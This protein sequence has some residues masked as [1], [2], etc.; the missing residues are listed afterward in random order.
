MC[1]RVHDSLALTCVVALFRMSGIPSPGSMLQKLKLMF[2]L[3]LIAIQR[4]L[5][6]L[7]QQ[8]QQAAAEGEGGAAATTGATAAPGG[9]S[10]AAS[11]ATGVTQLQLLTP[12]GGVRQL[13]MGHGHGRH[14]GPPEPAGARLLWLRRQD[15]MTQ[16]LNTVSQLH[17]HLK[18]LCRRDEQPGES[19]EVSGARWGGTRGKG[20]G[21]CA[22]G[23]GAGIPLGCFLHLVAA[24]QRRWMFRRWRRDQQGAVTTTSRTRVSRGDSRAPEI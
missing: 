12:S 2:N 19:P 4:N 9:A 22:D 24:C 18:Q 8:Q 3:E 16:L 23:T 21:T 10:T 6:L 1:W 13:T 17:D 15:E 5:A 20:L 11:V 14:H 7:Q